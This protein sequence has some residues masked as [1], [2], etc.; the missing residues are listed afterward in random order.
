MI[1]VA[2]RWFMMKDRTFYLVKLGAY[3]DTRC[4]FDAKLSVPQS[5]FLVLVFRYFVINFARRFDSGLIHVKSKIHNTGP[6]YSVKTYLI[7]VYVSGF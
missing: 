5:R 1:A 7:C 6:A 3:T 4:T 2:L